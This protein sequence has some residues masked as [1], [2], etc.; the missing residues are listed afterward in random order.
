MSLAGY[1]MRC[2]YVRHVSDRYTMEWREERFATVHGRSE[3]YGSGTA[4]WSFVVRSVVSYYRYLTAG[5]QLALRRY[6]KFSD[7][8]VI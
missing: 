6:A 2:Y 3:V 5:A 8:T 1:S 4:V 7:T